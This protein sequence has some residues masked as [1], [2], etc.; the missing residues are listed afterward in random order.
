M[1]PGPGL[2]GGGGGGC[3]SCTHIVLK[4]AG[5]TG[6]CGAAAAAR[7]PALPVAPAPGPGSAPPPLG[8]R[9][10]AQADARW[11]AG[12]KRAP[13]LRRGGMEESRAW[14]TD[15]RES[16]APRGLAAGAGRDQRIPA[17]AWGRS[18]LRLALSARRPRSWASLWRPEGRAPGWGTLKRP[19]LA[20]T[21]VRGTGSRRRGDISQMFM[22]IRWLWDPVLST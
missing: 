6:G 3:S 22:R 7:T 13:G 16:A 5:G 19:G 8:S 14:E 21:Q 9:S 2:G 11:A 18:S 12:Q 15:G 1:Q 4:S 10:C 17:L 20:A